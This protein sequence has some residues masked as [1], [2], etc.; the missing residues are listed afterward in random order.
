MIAPI[1]GALMSHAT[2]ARAITP[3]LF[4]TPWVPYRTG[5]VSCAPRAS[6]QLSPGHSAEFFCLIRTVCHSR[7]TAQISFRLA[8]NCSCRIKQQQLTYE[9][10]ASGGD[11]ALLFHDCGLGSPCNVCHCSHRKHTGS[12]TWRY[13]L[14][15]RLLGRTIAIIKAARRGA[16]KV[17]LTRDSRQGAVRAL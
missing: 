17:A 16:F 10:W 4:V 12:N 11:Y 5:W 14:H 9:C 13:C 1:R 2:T 3:A 8:A 6:D 15:R 7:S